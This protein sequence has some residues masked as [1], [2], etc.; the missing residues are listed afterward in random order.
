MNLEI[1]RFRTPAPGDRVAVFY[2]EGEAPSDPRR[3]QT[4]CHFHKTCILT[5]TPL[6][7]TKDTDIH[8]SRVVT[9]YLDG[10]LSERP[11]TT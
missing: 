1:R 9:W 7:T 3:R 8:Y 4:E 2:A 10:G 6:T 5:Q 11:R